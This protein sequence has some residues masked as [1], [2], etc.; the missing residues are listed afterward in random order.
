VFFE[1][2]CKDFRQYS[3]AAVISVNHLQGVGSGYHLAE[4]FAVAV[5]MALWTPAS[6]LRHVRMIGI[7]AIDKINLMIVPTQ[8]PA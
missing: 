2:I 1:L 7:K 8:Q 4:E 5:R 6:F 3:V